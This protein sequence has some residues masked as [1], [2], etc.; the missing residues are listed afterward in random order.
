MMIVNHL[1]NQFQEAMLPFLLRKSRNIFKRKDIIHHPPRIQN[2][3]EQKEMWSYEVRIL[4]KICVGKH[5]Y[6]Y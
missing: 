6:K 4:S 3:L 2:I 1:F 5:A